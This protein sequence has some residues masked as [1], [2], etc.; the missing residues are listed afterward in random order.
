MLQS[1][2]T[3]LYQKR[4]P[5][6]TYLLCFTHTSL[7]SMKMSSRRWQNFAFYISLIFILGILNT[8]FNLNDKWCFIMAVHHHGSQQNSHLWLNWTGVSE[9]KLC[10]KRK[11]L[12]YTHTQVMSSVW[13]ILHRQGRLKVNVR[14][15]TP[16]RALCKCV[17]V[18]VTCFCSSRWV[19]TCM[20]SHTATKTG[21]SR[22]TKYYFHKLKMHF[23]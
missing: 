16:L 2:F 17:C 3:F 11:I 10:V 19:R 22:H 14:V 20:P 18:W 13:W 9:E 23:V 12:S 8:Q 4:V 7:N 5:S 15:E 21:S 6:E 1:P